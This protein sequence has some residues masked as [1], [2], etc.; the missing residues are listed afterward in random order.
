M[1]ATGINYKEESVADYVKKHTQNLG[2]DI[3]YDSVGEKNL[4][5]SMQAAALSGAIA[6]TLSMVELDLT[7]AHIKGLS[8]HVVFMLIPMIHNI[9]REQ[10]GKILAEV[11]N[12]VEAGGLKPVLTERQFTLEQ[13][14][15]A[16]DYAASG[17]GMGKVVV[18]V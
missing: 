9:G 1:G 12:I 16:H 13:A 8:L 7:L 14:A 11:A 3:I 15:E 17:A 2:F 18:S 5:N 10:H 6:T 4:L